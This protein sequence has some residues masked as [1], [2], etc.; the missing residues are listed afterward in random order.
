MDHPLHLLKR[1]NKKKGR[2]NTGKTIK[3]DFVTRIKKN[4]SIKIQHDLASEK[5]EKLNIL[6]F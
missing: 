5:L 3:K 2:N 1:I 6:T 4:S